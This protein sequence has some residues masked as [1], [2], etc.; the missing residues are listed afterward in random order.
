MATGVSP[1]SCI[2]RSAVAD[3]YFGYLALPFNVSI[4]STV[5]QDFFVSTNGV[6]PVPLHLVI[7]YMTANNT[8]SSLSA[9][10]L[11]N[12]ST[13]HSLTESSKTPSEA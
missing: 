11:L 8:S 5:S 10:A 9:K 12:Y 4:F 2:T 6:S 3:D 13:A 7:D 1:I